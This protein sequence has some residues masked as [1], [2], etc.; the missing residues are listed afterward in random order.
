MINDWAIASDRKDLYTNSI[1]LKHKGE[2]RYYHYPTAQSLRT[3][4]LITYTG[5]FLVSL[6]IRAMYSPKTPIA[7]S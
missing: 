5:R 7:N 4:S 1:V 6:N 2:K 3:Y